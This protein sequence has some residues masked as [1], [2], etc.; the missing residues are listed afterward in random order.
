MVFTLIKC[1]KSADDDDC[2][3]NRRKA[4]SDYFDSAL[5]T[6][7]VKEVTVDRVQ[8]EYRSI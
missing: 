7:Y 1:E 5:K 4:V 3:R 8:T 6:V 2:N